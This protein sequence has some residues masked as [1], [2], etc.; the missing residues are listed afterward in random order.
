MEVWGGAGG[1]R[2]LPDP[3]RRTPMWRCGVGPGAGGLFLTPLRRTSMWRGGA[4]GWW[5]S[6]VLGEGSCGAHAQHDP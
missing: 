5:A 4:R 1:R 2:A 6:P 3:P